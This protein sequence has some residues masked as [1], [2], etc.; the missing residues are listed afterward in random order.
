MSEEWAPEA[1][2]TLPAG[3][4]GLVLITKKIKIVADDDALKNNLK[5]AQLAVDYAIK[6]T[7]VGSSNKFGDVAYSLGGS[8]GCVIGMRLELAVFGKN[9]GKRLEYI[10]ERAE[11]AKRTHCGNCGELSALAFIFLYDNGVRPIDVMEIANG[12]H[13]FVVVGRQKTRD[14]SDPKTW[15]PRS[16]IS[17]PWKKWV[18]PGVNAGTTKNPSPVGYTNSEYSGALVYD[19]NHREE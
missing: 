5:W 16:A 4:D 6:M 3:R 19:T 18:G 2:A 10:R 11:K 15:G 12:D 8:V 14:I 7:P 13:N 17:D 9:S 1:P